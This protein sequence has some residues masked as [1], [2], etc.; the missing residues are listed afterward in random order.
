MYFCAG[1][2]HI[3]GVYLWLFVLCQVIFPK[4]NKILGSGELK[5]GKKEHFFI[6]AGLPPVLP[7]VDPP[8]QVPTRPAGG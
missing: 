7:E 1:V 3:F 6:P 5:Y 2:V 8:C 4:A